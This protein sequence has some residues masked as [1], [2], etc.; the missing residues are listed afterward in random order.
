MK[1]PSIF[2]LLLLLLVIPALLFAFLFSNPDY[3]YPHRSSS[4]HGIEFFA[5]KTDWDSPACY[6]QKADIIN[7]CNQVQNQLKSSDLYD[8]VHFRAQVFFSQSRWLQRAHSFFLSEAPAFCLWKINGNI[9]Y[10]K[11]YLCFSS[12]DHL[13]ETLAHELT[14]KVILDKIGKKRYGKIPKWLME[15]YCEFVA[16]NY[17]NVST[18]HL[19]RHSDSNFQ[20]DKENYDNYLLTVCYLILYRKQT[21]GQLLANPPEYQK[22]WKEVEQWHFRSGNTLKIK[23]KL[24]V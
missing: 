15:G 19:N 10:Y 13:T 23:S 2:A 24:I 20:H 14:H 11:P 16:K 8:S 17:I 18:L 9:Y 7:I 22:I 5:E 3:F 21:I 1:I 4:V 12:D 6:N